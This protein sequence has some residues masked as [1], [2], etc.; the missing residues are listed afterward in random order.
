[1]DYLRRIDVHAID[2]RQIEE[3]VMWGI[4]AL[5]LSNAG[6]VADALRGIAEDSVHHTITRQGL[7]DHLSQRGYKLRRLTSP[8]S[9]RVA[10]DAATD[11]YLDGARRRLILDRL[12][13]RRATQALLSR[14][15]D[16]ATESVMTGR[17]GS[18]K[19]ACLVEVVD[20]LAGS[21]ASR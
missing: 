13:P 15:G 5:F 19:T 2:D 21:E 16:T 18:G 14:L 12:V 1:M 17:A 3:K 11:R 9:A 7:V 20:A 10:V 6:D 4:R 8:A